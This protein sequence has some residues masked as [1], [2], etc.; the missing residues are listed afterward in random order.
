MTL[1]RIETSLPGVL[2]IEPDIFKDP[3]GFFLETY[4]IGKYAEIG[5]NHTF[6]QDNRSHSRT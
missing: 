3:R 2:I 4:H 6:V 1:K 5:I